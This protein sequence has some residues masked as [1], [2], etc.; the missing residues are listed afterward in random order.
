MYSE[1]LEE[2]LDC[3]A[4]KSFGFRKLKETC[5]NSPFDM[6]CRDFSEV[7]VDKLQAFIPELLGR[8]HIESLLQG[9]VSEEVRSVS[10]KEFVS[11]FE[12]FSLFLI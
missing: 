12:C 4:G 8:L 5:R 1:K 6:F 9:N 2:N 11:H 3:P 10:D 7:T